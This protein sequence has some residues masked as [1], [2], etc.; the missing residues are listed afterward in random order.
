MT[1]REFSEALARNEVPSLLLFRGPEEYLKQSALQRLRRL[2]LPEG[3]EELNESR[4]DA[5]APDEIIAAAETLPFMAD[6]RIILLRDYPGL[7]GRGEADDRLVEY[8][9][10]VPPTS[11][12][13][14]YC[15]LPVKQKKIENAVKKHGAVVDFTALKEQELTSWVVRIFREQGRECDERTADALIFICGTDMTLLHSEIL[16]IASRHPEDPRIDPKDVQELATPSSET[17]VFR[18]VEAVVA[19]QEE[20]AFTHLRKLLLAGESRV[21]VISM[22]LRQFRLLQHIKIMQYEKRTPDEISKALGMKPWM[23]R[24]YTRQAG[25]FTGPQVRDAVSLCLNMELAVKSGRLRDEGALEA[26]MLKLLLLRK[27]PEK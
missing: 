7:V 23:L 16:K 15:V 17:V 10:S 12:L 9:P 27:S 11:V 26:L 3:L 2:L 20:Q 6:R 18:T 22:L 8:L 4:L 25:L 21:M 13:L 24:Q 5:P 14:F 19:G 1:P